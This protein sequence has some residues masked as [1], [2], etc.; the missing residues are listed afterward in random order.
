MNKCHVFIIFIFAKI[1]R[2]NSVSLASIEKKKNFQAANNVIVIS[3]T[4]WHVENH[5]TILLL[6]LLLLL[7]IIIKIIMTIKREN[8]KRV[9]INKI[10]MKADSFIFR[11]MNRVLFLTIVMLSIHLIFG[12]FFHLIYL[13]VNKKQKKITL[14]NIHVNSGID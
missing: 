7:L 3:R 1:R 9:T 12:S 8:E 14:P 6:L 5:I 13:S 2:S 10:N 4:R 11:F